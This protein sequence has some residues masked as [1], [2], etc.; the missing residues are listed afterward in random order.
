M[1]RLYIG[2]KDVTPFLNIGGDKI[3]N[4]TKTITENGTYTYDDGYTGLDKVIVNV[5]NEQNYCPVLLQRAVW[6]N[7]STR[8]VEY[9]RI[10]KIKIGYKF[11]KINFKK[12]HSFYIITRF[13]PLQSYY[14]Q[15]KCL[16]KAGGF[17]INV[18]PQTHNTCKLKVSIDFENGTNITMTPD[19]ILEKN[20]LYEVTFTHTEDTIQS[21]LGLKLREG[22]QQTE[23]ICS[24]PY[25]EW[26]D[27]YVVNDKDYFSFGYDFI[28]RQGSSQYLYEFTGY[29]DVQDTTIQ[30]YYDFE[31]W[32]QPYKQFMWFLS[33]PATI[34]DT[35]H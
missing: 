19:R 24:L 32:S 27:S 22:A 18:V 17:Q 25:S 21:P 6:H 11:P 15:E 9:G 5:V 16:F 34:I 30:F 2:D 13:V 26:P 29:F 23:V 12:V 8:I 20:K 28:N 1:G 14:T 3:K 31:S 35:Q 4:Q 33:E 10:G 7:G